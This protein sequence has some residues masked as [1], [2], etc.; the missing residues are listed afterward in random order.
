M[1][2]ELTD[3]AVRHALL[4]AAVM[5]ETACALNRYCRRPDNPPADLA[6]IVADGLVSRRY[7][8]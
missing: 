6:G 3:I 8:H 1:T 2:D 5:G 7:A 4:D